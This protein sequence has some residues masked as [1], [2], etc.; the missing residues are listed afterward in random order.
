MTA[1]MPEV[2]FLPAWRRADAQIERDARELWRSQEMAPATIEQQIGELAAAAYIGERLVAVS[3][4]AV[5]YF[6]PMKNNFLLYRCLVAPEQRRQDLAWRISAWS[7][8]LLE[9]WS[10]NNPGEKIIGLM[11]A[12]ETDKFAEQQ[13]D[14]QRTEAGLTLNFVGYTRTG[15]QIR[16]AWFKH[17][18]L[19]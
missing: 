8:D 12:L 13:R 17:A 4:A 2:L 6:P 5:T 1:T 9:Q 10:L 3:T 18:I 7:R 14:P 19:E 11:M 16:V 15:D